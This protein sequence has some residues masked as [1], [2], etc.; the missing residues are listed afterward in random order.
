VLFHE[1]LLCGMSTTPTVHTLG[2]MAAD[3]RGKEDPVVMSIS[4][5]AIWKRADLTSML[6]WKVT[7]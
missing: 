7:L 2:D 1:L 6:L 5:F 3:I 4:A